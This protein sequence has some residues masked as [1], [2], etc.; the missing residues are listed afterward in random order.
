[1]LWNM[2]STERGERPR[3]RPTPAAP[4]SADRRRVHQPAIAPL[5]V[6][7]ACDADRS[8]VALVHFAV[9]ADRLDGTRKPVVVQAE[10]LADVARAAEQPLHRGLL[11]LC[12][13][14]VDVGRRD[15]V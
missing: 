6:L 9:V 12:L 3:E 4:S 15:T 2:R 1:S 14:F 11:A 13:P 8:D 7:P 5:R 10:P